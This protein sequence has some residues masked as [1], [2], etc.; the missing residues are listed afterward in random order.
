MSILINVV[1][2]MNILLVLSYVVSDALVN[3]VKDSCI[4]EYS[5]TYDILTLIILLLFCI[6]IFSESLFFLPFF[7][8]SFH[9]TCSSMWSSHSYCTL[10][11]WEVTSTNT[12]LLSNSGLSLGCTYLVYEIYVRSVLLFFCFLLAI[13]FCSLQIKEN[14]NITLF[15]NESIY[16]CVFYFLTS[17]HMFHVVVGI[18]LLGLVL[19]TYC[20]SRTTLNFLAFQQRVSSSRHLFYTLQLV[21]W[22]FVE[23]LWLF[24]YYVLYN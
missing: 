1:I 3:G 11:P 12:V 20:Y 22:H 17:L 21:Y 13:I 4:R 9:A 19:S 24:I 18:F 8:A 10:D 14:R 2:S 16:N 5:S 23:L 7:W 15:M 6:M